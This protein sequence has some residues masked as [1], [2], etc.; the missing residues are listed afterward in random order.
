MPS[1]GSS[2]SSSDGKSLRVSHT[3]MSYIPRGHTPMSITPHE[4][5]LQEPHTPGATLPEATSPGAILVCLS[6]L[7]WTYQYGRT[8]CETQLLTTVDKFSV[9]GSFNVLFWSKRL[10]WSMSKLCLLMN[11]FTVSAIATMSLHVQHR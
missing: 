4:P 6:Y 1:E 9:A 11:E 8:D 5:R 10:L 7:P 3:P 2:T